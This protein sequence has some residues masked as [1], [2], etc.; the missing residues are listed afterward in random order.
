VAQT[1]SI[2]IAKLVNDLRRHFRN[3]KH[4]V[5]VVETRADAQFLV[6]AKRPYVTGTPVPYIQSGTG[7]DRTTAAP[8]YVAEARVCERDNQRCSDLTA[9]AKLNS[10]A[11]L[12]LADKILAFVNTGSRH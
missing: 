1:V 4:G 2:W 10:M 11:T 5:R 3:P 9:S 8:L 12:Q 6:E 7:D